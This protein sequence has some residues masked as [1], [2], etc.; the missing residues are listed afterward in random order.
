MKTFH[1]KT[2][3]CQMNHCDTD[4]IRLH[5]LSLGLSEVKDFESA[6]LAVLNTCSVRQKAEDKVSGI[7]RRLID[8]KK[9]RAGFKVVMTGCMAQ[10]TNRKSGMEN[11]G[12]KTHIEKQFEWVDHFV[13]IGM[14]EKWNKIVG[15]EKSNKE[16][17]N[18]NKS[19]TI[20]GYVPISIGCNN[21]CS[22]CVVPYS[23]GGEIS[24]EYELI[25]KRIDRVIEEGA[26]IVI[27]LGQNVNSWKGKIDGKEVKFPVLLD[28][29]AKEYSDYWISFM[30]SHPK[31]FDKHLIEVMKENKNICKYLNLPIQSGSNKVLSE[32]N[33]KYTRSEYLNKIKLLRREI[34][35]IRLS[36]DLIVGFSGEGKNEFEET[37]DTIKKCGF[38]MAYISEYSVREGT[39]GFVLKDDVSLE[40]KK[41]SLLAMLELPRRFMLL[42][43]I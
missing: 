29:V 24:I 36:T 4:D 15:I 35:D 31:D 43:K 42:E 37:V 18:G 33:R 26:K 12:Y 40:D 3:G 20:I 11:R 25:K 2:W 16:A 10:R 14:L 13:P 30:T 9:K 1:I 27:L 34:P 8:I 41:F 32:M 28:K 39:S 17:V 5:L 6:D 23:R 22:Y 21:F 19:G 38:S 7:G